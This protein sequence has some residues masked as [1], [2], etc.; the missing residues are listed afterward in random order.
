[1]ASRHPI[2]WNH[3]SLRRIELPM[4]VETMRYTKRN[5][6]KSGMKVIEFTTKVSTFPEISFFF[7]KIVTISDIFR[8]FT[9]IRTTIGRGLKRVAT[10]RSS[11]RYQISLF[12]QISKILLGNVKFDLICPIFK[13][14]N[15][16]AKPLDMEYTFQRK[17]F[18]A[19]SWVRK[20]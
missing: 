15:L 9:S 17:M 18:R 14:Q 5:W 13:I 3:E 12:A 19:N 1:M 7:N 8:K 11:K 16:Q 2:C 4:S 6:G 20:V 10:G